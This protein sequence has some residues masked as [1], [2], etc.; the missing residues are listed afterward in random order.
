[1][2]LGAHLEAGAIGRELRDKSRSWL[3][4]NFHLVAAEP[5][6]LQL[7]VA[8][9]APLVESDDVASPEEFIFAAVMAWV[10]EDEAG[11]KTELDRLLPLVRF[12]LMAKAPLLMMAEP[13]AAQHPLGTQLMAEAHAAFAASAQAAACPR[14]RP[15]KGFTRTFTVGGE[16]VAFA[17]ALFGPDAAALAPLAAVPAAPLLADAEL[18]NAAELCGRVAVVRRGGGDGLAFHARARRA[19]QAGAVAV[20]II[21]NKGDTPVVY[22]N[23]GGQAADIAIPALCVGRADGERLLLGGAALVALAYDKPA[24]VARGRPQAAAQAKRVVRVAGG[25]IA[26]SG[27]PDNRATLNAPYAPTGDLVDGYPSFSAGAEKHLFR[28]PGRDQWY[29]SYSPFDA[30]DYT[31]V[32]KIDAVG[33]PVPTG[34]R[35]WV[36]S[37][38]KGG[39]VTAAVAACEVA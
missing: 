8:A 12:P 5:S 2:A 35:T 19:Q 4:T 30:A 11:R 3:N 39:S 34:A 33:G 13:L 7:P 20:I 38:G 28:H 6:F 15:R 23:G 22:N 31:C 1:M 9:L 17:L 24:E 10:K 21:N 26:I 14:L 29:L 37:D 36:V 18:T 25:C 27:L 32:A 16:A